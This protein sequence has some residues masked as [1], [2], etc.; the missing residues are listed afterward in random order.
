[1]ANLSNINNKFL[2]TT[3]GNVLIGGTAVVGAA[4]LQVTGEARVYTGSNLGYWGVDAGNS[5]VYLGTNSSAYGLSLQT[6]GIDRVNINDAGNVFI[7][8][9]ITNAFYGL[10]LTYNNTNTADFTVNQATGQIK[11]GGV[12]TGYF[13]TFY[14]AGVERMRISSSGNATFQESIIFNNGAPF[15]AAASIRQQSDILILT[16]GGNGFAFNDDTNAVSNM[17]IDSGGN[18]GIGTVSPNTALQVNQSTTVPLL[19]HRQSNTNFDPHG[20]G[21]ST[22]SDAID[23]GL[24]DVRSGIFSDYNGD[25][26]LAA[27]TSSITTSPLTYSRLFIEGGNG[28]VGIGT[29]SPDALLELEKNPG[30]AALGPVLLL[31]N[32]AGTIGDQGAIIFSSG[33][34]TYQRAKIQFTVEDD[35]HASDIQF[36]TGRSDLG[37][38]TS[39]MTILGNGKVGIGTATPVGKTDIFVGASGYT[40]NVTTLPVGTWSFAN[41]SGSNS[42]PSLVSKSNATG[43]GMT[44][45]AATD[46]GAPNGMDFNIRKGDN[47]DFSTLT[48][49]GFTF[50]RFGTV[51]T[52]ILRNGNVG[53]GI[54]SPIAQLDVAG[55]TNQHHSVSTSNNGTWRS[56]IN[57]GTVGWLDQTY[58]AGRVKIYGSENGNTNVSYCEYYVLRSGSG[59]HIQQIGTRLDVGNTHGQIEARISGNFLQ[60][61]NVANSS[62]GIVRAVLSAMKN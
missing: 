32:S 26:F 45:L 24:G 44:L 55:N 43:A 7:S 57:L 54:T 18:V 10:S 34:N 2:V 51:L 39:K 41:G 15:A 42:Y 61:K 6:G 35:P 37:T 53:I 40:N 33:G 1:M 13:P 21:F 50:S 23:G 29:T 19:V 28:N 58:S 25:L 47:T 49:S 48:T 14:S 52:T 30:T 31:N 8:T 36:Y 56:M 20:I 17:I 22:R 59:Y 27:A 60:V 16:G 12:A 11:I 3:G 62:L 9:P 5:Y 46:D 38:L 4:K